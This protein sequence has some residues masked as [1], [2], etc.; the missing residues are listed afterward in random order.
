MRRRSF[1]AAGGVGLAAACTRRAGHRAVATRD[2]M[3]YRGKLAEKPRYALRRR[4]KPRQAGRRSDRQQIP[5]PRL[6]RRRDRARP[7]RCS[8]QS[9]TTR[10][11][12]VTPPAIII[13]GKDPTF[14]FDCTVPF[15]MNTR[16]MNAWIIQGGGRE[17]MRAL[18]KDYNV[19]NIPAGN[20][21][22]QMGGWFRKEIKTVA[23][24]NGLKFRI[25]GLAGAVADQARRRA[26][27][28]RRRRHL[29]GAGKGHD[30]RG[31]MGR[32]L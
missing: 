6:R 1:I 29:S 28:D 30:R 21:G 10:S 31:G 5:D 15:G 27:A 32:P 18:F 17:L 25:A 20:T 19:Y 8:T 24:L 2:Q 7:C 13:V 3:A 11:R 9:R 12:S 4:R 22:A 26:A 23:D 16:Q 14:S